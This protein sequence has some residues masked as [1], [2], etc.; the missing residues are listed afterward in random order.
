MS[1]GENELAGK[2]REQFSKDQVKFS[3]ME[4]QDAT[5]FQLGAARNKAAVL[6]YYTGSVVVQGANCRLKEYCEDVK[7]S[8]LNSTFAPITTLPVEIERFP[9]TLQKKVPHCDDVVV[10][11]YNEAIRCYKGHSTAGAAFML[12]AASEKAILLLIDAFKDNIADDKNRERFRSKVE[13]RYISYIYQIFIK[14]YKSS[15]P[16]LQDGSLSRDLEEFL[17][18]AFH[19]YRNT[20]NQVGHPHIIPDLDEGV[21]LASMGHFITYVQRIYGLIE[22]FNANEI[23][24]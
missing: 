10:W 3:E 1:Q 21:V 12:G 20:R 8:I 5:K 19:Y 15:R 2:F 4:V 18:S 13:N 22:F 7:E 24:L 23:E 6:V 9:E 14:S 17:N 16:R 11:F